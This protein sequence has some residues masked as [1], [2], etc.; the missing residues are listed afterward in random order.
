[1][2]YVGD[3][4]L[5]QLRKLFS[6]IKSSLMQ[7]FS[8]FRATERVYFKFEIFGRFLEF[9]I[10]PN[11]GGAHSSG[12]RFG[13]RALAFRQWLPPLCQCPRIR[14]TAPRAIRQPYPRRRLATT[15]LP[16]PLRHPVGKTKCHF[17][18]RADNRCS[19]LL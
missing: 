10:N 14:P 6:I 17:P 2:K 1:M 4:K 3:L 18:P 8:I 12:S 5:S 16:A 13:H 9:W 7:N 11:P 15:T 19:T